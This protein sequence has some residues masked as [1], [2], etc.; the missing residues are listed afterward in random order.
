MKKVVVGSNNPI[1]L[2]TTKEAFGALFPNDT[3]E[4]VTFGAVS[5]VPDQPFGSDETKTGAENRAAHCMNELSGADFYVGL[6]GGIEK[7]GTEHWAF[8]WMCVISP[9]R[10]R[11]YGKTGSFM[12]PPKISVLINEGVEL[13]HATDMVFSETNSGHKEGTIGI[14]TNEAITRKDFYREAM[15]FALV[16]FARP[17]LYFNK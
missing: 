2:E 13:G 3:F 10:K 14:L 1:K 6:E 15:I 4:F 7:V 11:G 8:A 5:G 17:E 9:E 12:L 16:P